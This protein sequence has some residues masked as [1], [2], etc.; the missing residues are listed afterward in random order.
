MYYAANNSYA[1]PTSVG[2][3]NTWYVVGFATKADRDAYVSAADGMAARAIT[4]REVKSY[5]VRETIRDGFDA[6]R[7]G[8][9]VQTGAS[10]RSE[11]PNFVHIR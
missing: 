7:I 10:T 8:Y 11:Y 9:A 1:S 2:F 4:R 6:G 5:A 3:D